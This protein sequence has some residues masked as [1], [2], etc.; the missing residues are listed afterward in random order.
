MTQKMALKLQLEDE[1]EAA[2]A[3]LQLSLLLLL[4]LARHTREG[5]KPSIL[6]ISENAAHQPKKR[7]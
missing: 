5:V 7:K 4:L 2:H 6:A 3:L 1:V